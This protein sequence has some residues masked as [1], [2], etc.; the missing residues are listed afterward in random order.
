MKKRY[1][2][3][4]A[5]LIL[6]IAFG[7]A[8]HQKSE[9]PSYRVTILHFNDIHGYI[10]AHRTPEGQMGGIARI[11]ALVKSIQKENQA[12]GV[13][14]LL[15]FAGDLIQGSPV[16]TLFH[17]TQ[18]MEMLGDAGV[19]LATMGNHA[20]DYGQENFYALLEKSPYPW[21][22][23]NVDKKGADGELVPI[24]KPGKTFVLENGLRVG[25]VGV[26]TGELVTATNPKNVVGIVAENP[27][28]A[29]RRHLPGFDAESELLILLSHC[30]IACDKKMAD[31]FPNVDLIVG[32]HNHNLYRQPIMENNVAIVQA[33][34][35]GEYLGRA[36]ILV[37]GDVGKV[38]S[39][40]VYPI[41]IDLSEDP[42]VA[43]KV[44]AVMENVDERGQEVI[45]KAENLLDGNR[46]T[47][48]RAESNFGDLVCDLI[49]KR[50]GTD[51][52][53]INGGSFRAS[54]NPGDIK[55]ADV[56]AVFPFGNTLVKMTVS[57]DVI[58]Q[59][60]ER[61]L[62]DDP[63]DNP[64][65]FAQISGVAYEIDG[66][67]AVNIVINGAPIDLNKS[68][69]LGTNG[70]MAS[71]GD[72]FEML[73]DIRDKNDTGLTPADVIMENFRELKVIKAGTD[74]RI[75]RIAP[76]T[77][78]GQTF[79]IPVFDFN[80]DGRSFHLAASF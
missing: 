51:V 48:R 29:V 56:L 5:I 14:T 61:G 46:E 4:A 49:R 40:R 7:C 2:L 9:A 65:S 34:Q 66:R 19:N 41:T 22:T 35:Y 71:G 20:F 21:V 42:E 23:C 47:V 64:G 53:L 24:L 72:G 26:V 78:A 45:A 63:E 17:G 12:K 16:S 59:A 32:G 73:K 77:P 69:S 13:P 68:Y 52:V 58:R 8:T 36:D 18:T 76:W 62:Q 11:D 39:Y 80:K 75:K 70:F 74:G 25:V 44:D 60:I 6:L 43:A 55:V 10:E 30:G 50:L 57:G 31:A 37:E 15:L 38:E 3:V 79:L 28:D 67:K 54:I 33:G 1:S 27:I